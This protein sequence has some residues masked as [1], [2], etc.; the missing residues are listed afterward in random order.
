MCEPQFEIETLIR[1]GTNVTYSREYNCN[2]RRLFPWPGMVETKRPVSEFGCIWVVVD[3]GCVVDPHEHD[4]EEAFI[5]VSGRA[6]ITVHGQRTEIRAGDVAYIPRFAHHEISNPS[7]TEQF[8]MIDLYWD[9]RAS[10][11]T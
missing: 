10:A 6:R 8:V 11:S 4:E 3:P 5:A 2:L 1:R 7:D 9:N